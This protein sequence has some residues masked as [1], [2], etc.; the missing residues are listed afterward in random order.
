MANGAF[1]VRPDTLLSLYVRIWIC[2]HAFYF[3]NTIGPFYVVSLS[4]SAFM[5]L[6]Q[7]YGLPILAYIRLHYSSSF[8]IVRDFSPGDDLA[9]LSVQGHNV[10]EVR[11]EFAQTGACIPVWNGFTPIMCDAYAEMMIRACFQ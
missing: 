7:F 5:P 10:A 9:R 1:D 11:D 3:R 4:P 2:V 8:V 6:A